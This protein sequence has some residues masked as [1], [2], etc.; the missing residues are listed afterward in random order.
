[1]FSTIVPAGIAWSRR[2]ALARAG[3]GFGAVAWAGLHAG[4]APAASGPHLPRRAKR[5]IFLFMAG[6]VSQV[7]SFDP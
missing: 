3:C 4:T 6:G 2:A 7:D 1:M 5:M